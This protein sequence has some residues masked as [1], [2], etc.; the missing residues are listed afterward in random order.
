VIWVNELKV[1]WLV[2]SHNLGLMNRLEPDA[3]VDEA[4]GDACEGEVGRVGY[5][6]G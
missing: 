4:R 5:E 2:T 1:R 3:W 6:P